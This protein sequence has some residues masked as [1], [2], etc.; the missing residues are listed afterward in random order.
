[1]KVNRAG[2]EFTLLPDELYAAHLEWEHDVAY[3]FLY[4]R[5]TGVYYEWACSLSGPSIEEVT[6][7]AVGIFLKSI[8]YD[9]TREWSYDNAVMEIIAK[10]ANENTISSEE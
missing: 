9:C 8:E 2:L 4:A 6:E 3:G 7:E 10:Y 1:M 5:L